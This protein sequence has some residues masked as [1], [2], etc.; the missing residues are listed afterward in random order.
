[1]NK[2]MLETKRRWNWKEFLVLVGLIIPATFAILPY[3]INLQ[4][5]YSQT[6]TS[7]SVGWEVLVLN[8][9]INSLLISALGGI[10]LL[11]AH[12]IGLGMPFVEGWVKRELIPYRFRNVV[13]IAWIAAVVLV[14]SSMFLHTVVLD[15]PLNAMLEKM[16]ITI[17]EGAHTLPLYGFLAAFSA[18]ITEETLFRLVGLSLLA[19]LGGLLFHQSDGRPK[20]IIFWIANVLFALGFGVVHLQKVAVMGWPINSLVITYTLILNAIGGLLFGWLFWTFGL[21]SAMLGHFFADVILYTLIPFIE[22]QDGEIT[23]NRAMAGV[24]IFVLLALVWAWKTLV[25]ENRRLATAIELK[26]V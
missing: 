6:D 8:Q 20:R 9:L 10:G 3:L 11:L 16:G 7:T 22:M 4:T 19:W 2:I 17:P 15:P 1:M 12:R 23:R 5:T 18:G 21:E 13:S 25:A 24:I 14:L 26:G